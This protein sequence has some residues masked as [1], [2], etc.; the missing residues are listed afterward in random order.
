MN[1]INYENDIIELLNKKSQLNDVPIA[2]KRHL[3]LGTT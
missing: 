2:I 3:K 1:D